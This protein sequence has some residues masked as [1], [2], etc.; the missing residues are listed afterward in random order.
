MRPFTL[1]AV[2]FLAL[3][4]VAAPAA[5]AHGGCEGLLDAAEWGHVDRVESLLLQGVDVDCRNPA[6]ATALMRAAGYGRVAVVR[7]LLLHGADVKAREESSLADAYDYAE[8]IWMSDN[9]QDVRDAEEIFRLLDE[10]GAV[11]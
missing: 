10:A 9:A 2:I 3:S 7:L 4:W 1:G 5:A 11:E 6:G 8:I